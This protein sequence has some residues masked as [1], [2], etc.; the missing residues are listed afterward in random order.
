MNQSIKVIHFSGF[1][2]SL[3]YNVLCHFRYLAPLIFREVEAAGHDFLAHVFRDG[4]AVVLGIK[5]RITAQHHI[6]NYAQG[7][8]V[9]AL[10][11]KMN[12]YYRDSQKKKSLEMI[13]KYS[14]SLVVHL[15]HIFI[16]S[17]VTG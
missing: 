10:R 11:T 4:A 17:D 15:H 8:Q 14:N 12:N 5:W 1:P 3:A 16:F 6:D 2:H 13:S 9:T 7:P